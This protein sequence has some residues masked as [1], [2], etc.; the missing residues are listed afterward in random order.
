MPDYWVWPFYDDL[1]FL[2]LTSNLGVTWPVSVLLGY[3]P[4]NKGFASYARQALVLLQ[5]MCE[6]VHTWHQFG[7]EQDV[8]RGCC[9]AQ[10]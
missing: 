2:L 3:R 10:V 4:L 8:Q 7:G 9:L 5:G 6:L 1:K